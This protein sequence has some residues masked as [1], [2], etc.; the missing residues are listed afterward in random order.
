M[1]FYTEYRWFSKTAGITA[2]VEKTGV[3]IVSAMRITAGRSM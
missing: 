1:H 3:R 2:E